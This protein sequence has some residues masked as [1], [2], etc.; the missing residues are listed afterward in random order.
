MVDQFGEGDR[1]VQGAEKLGCE[2]D[3]R[4]HSFVP[5]QREQQHRTDAV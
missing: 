4:A 3:V 1:L 2:A 5:L